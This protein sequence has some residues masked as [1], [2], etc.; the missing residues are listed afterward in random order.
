M[1]AGEDRELLLV[2]EVVLD[3]NR[4][5]Q[6]AVPRR[7]ARQRRDHEPVERDERRARRLVLR[8]LVEGRFDLLLADD[9][10]RKVGALLEFEPVGLAHSLRLG[11]GTEHLAELE[12]VHARLLHRQHHLIIRGEPGSP[13]RK[14]VVRHLGY[15]ILG[16]RDSRV[17]RLLEINEV[18]DH[19]LEHVVGECLPSIRTLGRDPGAGTLQLVERDLQVG[20]QNRRVADH[21][22]DPVE[23]FH[24]G[25]KLRRDDGVGRRGFVLLKRGERRAERE[26]RREQADAR[27]EGFHAR[28]ARI[29]IDHAR[30][31]PRSPELSSPSPPCAPAPRGFQGLPPASAGGARFP[32]VSG[33]T[34]TVQAAVLQRATGGPRARS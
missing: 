34:I 25:G 10:R 11:L 15:A 4:A 3:A 20:E 9:D 13:L 31:L 1:A 8:E 32:P 7:T 18:V 27:P 23:R 22:H 17:L 5:G 16:N 2:R 24:A 29:D 6:D 28:H 33:P 14:D 21:G 19:R 12:H 26:R 30:L